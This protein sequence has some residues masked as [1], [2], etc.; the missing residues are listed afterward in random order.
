MTR[1]PLQDTRGTALQHQNCPSRRGAA[2]RGMRLAARSGTGIA[3]APVAPDEH[4]PRQRKGAT[5]A[6]PGSWLHHASPCLDFSL[7]LSPHS[8]FLAVG[9]ALRVTPAPHRQTPHSRLQA[10]P[11]AVP[12][13]V[14]VVRYGCGFGCRLARVWCQGRGG[15]GVWVQAGQAEGTVFTSCTNA[16]PRQCRGGSLSLKSNIHGETFFHIIEIVSA[17]HWL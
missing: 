10:R 6:A 16:S 14:H 17:E 11:V 3:Q 13:V 9:A 2:R 8:S 12:R 15:R 4:R 5:T 7:S 1:P